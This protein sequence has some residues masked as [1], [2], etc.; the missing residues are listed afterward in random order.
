[1]YWWTIFFFG[2]YSIVCVKMKKR[3]LEIRRLNSSCPRE[4]FLSFI[5]SFLRIC[6][7]VFRFLLRFR[8]F[9]FILFVFLF[10]LQIRFGERTIV[11][12]C[13]CCDG[14]VHF[15]LFTCVCEWRLFL[16]VEREIWYDVTGCFI[17]FSRICRLSKD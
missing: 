11:V 1:M 6:F 10:W 12:F 13:C 7:V 3:M 16:L 8:V 2:F 4:R 17:Y 9:L 5:F 15:S 14:A